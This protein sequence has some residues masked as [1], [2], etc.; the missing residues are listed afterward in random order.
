MIAGTISYIAAI[1]RFSILFGGRDDDNGSILGSLLLLI[2]TPIIAMFIQL[3]I[4]RTRE[5]IA[6]SSAARTLNSSKGLASALYKLEHSDKREFSGN[7]A[8]VSLFIVNPLSGKML[9]KL[10]STHP[11][12]EE[13]I[14]RL[15]NLNLSLRY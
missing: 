2:L 11:P 13:R 1:G 10:F 8:G 14:N 5:Y 7:V 9:L 6:D 3:A 4:S 12:M 15:N